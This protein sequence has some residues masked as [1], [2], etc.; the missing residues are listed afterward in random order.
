MTCYLKLSEVRSSSVTLSITSYIATSHLTSSWEG[1]S[2]LMSN[3]L[4]LRMKTIKMK[5][6]PWSLPLTSSC[7]RLK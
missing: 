2:S 3:I 4:A 7:L 5:R 1:S 6:T